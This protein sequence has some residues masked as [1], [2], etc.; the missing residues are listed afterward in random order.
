VK[1]CVEKN[2]CP[3]RKFAVSMIKQFHFDIS[4][5]LKTLADLFMKILANWG[6]FIEPDNN[7]WLKT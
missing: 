7:Q 6:C 5:S 2:L 3:D 1:I 4:A